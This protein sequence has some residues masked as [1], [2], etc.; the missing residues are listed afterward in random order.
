MN[1]TTTSSN[2]ISTPP[3]TSQL[4]S[5]ATAAVTQTAQHCVPAIITQTGQRSLPA[6]VT[7]TSHRRG[8]ATVIQA[9]QRSVAATVTKTTA[10][11]KAVS[12]M[13]V[14]Q[15]GND[16]SALYKYSIGWSAV[17]G[18]PEEASYP[19]GLEVLSMVSE[20]QAKLLKLQQ[21][22]NGKKSRR[23]TARKR[24][25]TPINAVGTPASS[26]LP[27]P[28][29][30]PLHK[31]PMTTVSTSS[32]AIM[33]TVVKTG[34]LAPSGQPSEQ[35][36]TSSIGGKSSQLSL[37]KSSVSK[38]RHTARKSNKRLVEAV[39][40][41]F[42]VNQTKTG[43]SQLEIGQSGMSLGDPAMK[44]PA[45]VTSKVPLDLID[46]V[47]PA[48]VSTSELAAIQSRGRRSVANTI[49]PRRQKKMH[50]DLEE[51]AKLADPSQVV[52]VEGG[53]ECHI[54]GKV[55]AQKANVRR[56]YRYH[57]RGKLGKFKCKF[58]GKCFLQTRDIEMHERTHTGERPFRC[59]QCP[60]QFAQ[61]G[62]LQRHMKSHENPKAY[63]CQFCNKVCLRVRAYHMHV[64][65]HFGSNRRFKCD[66]CRLGFQEEAELMKHLRGHPARR[67]EAS[68][69]MQNGSVKN[70]HVS[71]DDETADK[72]VID[73]TAPESNT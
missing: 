27:F 46:L 12:Q 35:T 72:L 40:K 62:N 57:S 32:T 68:T 48:P 71:S 29:Y 2:S 25:K 65:S 51:E 10:N 52:P 6:T 14:N 31:P 17:N 20:Q 15:V 56:H 49:P 45:E 43:E 59:S 63:K 69:V 19:S 73:E 60:R 55:I 67:S 50:G 66:V 28:K 16:P 22:K 42:G 33:E 11:Q 64:A 38:I 61:L 3:T 9:D 7:Q 30:S 44:P 47:S 18:L 70:G 54:C 58:C 37:L 8:P 21:A 26:S 23:N 24:T 1:N 4:S 41:T 39:D 34:M 13:E 36:V 53:F 5:P